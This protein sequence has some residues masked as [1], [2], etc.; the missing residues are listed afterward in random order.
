[1]AAGPPP[2]IDRECY[3][4]DDFV[5]SCA[6]IFVWYATH[7]FA[8]NGDRKAS[9]NIG[10]GGAGRATRQITLHKRPSCRPR[11]ERGKM[12]VPN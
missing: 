5:T 4:L 2:I 3:G 11:A 8:V 7:P 9:R 1:M 12:F 6:A 10:S